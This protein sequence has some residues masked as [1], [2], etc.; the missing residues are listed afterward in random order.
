M[1]KRRPSNLD[2]HELLSAYIDDQV[3]GEERQQVEALLQQDPE[4]AQ[5]FAWL[6]Y[7]VGLLAELP[8]QPVPRAFTL[9]EEVV[10]PQ[11][12]IGLKWLSWLNPAY[13]RGATALVAICL[14]VLFVG[15]LSF[16]TQVAPAPVPTAIEATLPGDDLG[17]ETTIVGKK[18]TEDQAQVTA[19]VRAVEA[20]GE[21]QA[22]Q[23][24]GLPAGLLVALEIGLV[25]LLALLLIAQWQVM[26]GI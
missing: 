23:F 7:T 13:L 6:R 1:P 24:L 8:R 9:N 19:E 20:A 5:E 3:D 2:A 11:P 14:M 17:D 15:D 26:R 25:I 18:A 4:A 12:G 21:Q 22:S 10:K 16:R